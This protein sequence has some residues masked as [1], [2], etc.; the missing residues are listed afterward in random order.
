MASCLKSRLGVTDWQAKMPPACDHNID[1][2][3][4]VAV[5]HILQNILQDKT[6]EPQLLSTMD[7]RM[8]D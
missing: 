1:R 8:S 2:R 7:M 3:N 4:P 6:P 5:G